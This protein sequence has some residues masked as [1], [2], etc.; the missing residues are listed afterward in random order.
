MT[1]VQNYDRLERSFMPQPAGR[2]AAGAFG[3]RVFGRAAPAPADHLEVDRILARCRDRRI[4]TLAPLSRR[5][6]QGGNGEALAY[7]A[8]GLALLALSAISV[9]PIF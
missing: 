5:R 6:S 9:L 7:V 3:R 8:T 4:E 2:A 1:T